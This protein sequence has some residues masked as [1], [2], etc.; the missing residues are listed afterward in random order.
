MGTFRR[1]CGVLLALSMVV[2]GSTIARAQT[3]PAAAPLQAPELT[4]AQV[5]AAINR[6]LDFLIKDIDKK[7][8]PVKRAADVDRGRPDLL[9]GSPGEFMLE[10]YALLYAGQELRDP[11]LAFRDQRVQLIKD[12]VTRLESSKLQN[13]ETYTTALQSL[14]LSQMPRV[15][16]VTNAVNRVTK[17]LVGGTTSTGGYEYKL[18]DQNWIADGSNS[19]YGLLGVW[20]A[21][22]WG[23][24]VPYN[25]WKF[26]DEY[27]R[28]VQSN[29]GGW[30]YGQRPPE[31]ARTGT[32]TASMTA[33]GL[34]SL[35]VCGEFLDRTPHLDM[36]SDAVIDKGMAAFVDMFD[37]K[38]ND[39]YYLYGVE[40]VGLASGLKFIGNTNWYRVI[41]ANLVKTQ[42]A[43]GSFEGEFLGANAV[44]GTCYALLFLVRGRAPIVMNKLQYDGDW[45][46][47]PRDSANVHAYLT[48][49]FER[50]LNWQVVPVGVP[51]EEWLDAP[52]LYIAGSK[53]PNFS[54]E[55]VEKLKAFVA[56]GGIIFSVAEGGGQ[57]AGKA[58]S[59]AVAGYAA[60]IL[61]HT[62]PADADGAPA[63]A[64]R[65]LPKD[66]PLFSVIGRPD[67]LPRLMGIS[68]GV[69]ELW[70][71]S[72][73]DYGAIWQSRDE[74]DKNTW[75]LPARIFM[76][77]AS[78]NGLHSKLQ[79]LVAANDH[80]SAASMN[81]ARLE[82]AGNWDPEPGAWPRLAK[83]LSADAHT[84]LAIDTV[85]PEQLDSLA[86]KPALAHLAGVGNLQLTAEQGRALQS[87]VTGG[88]TL[89]VEAMAGD[90]AFATS[91][92][93]MLAGLFPDA[94]LKAVPDD[95]LLYTGAFS[96]DAAHITEVEY[97][98]NWILS[99]GAQSKPRLQYM[100][101]EG[102]V[103]VLFSEEDIT[104]GLLGL[105]TWGVDGYVPDSAVA[106]ARNIVL[107]A[108]INQKK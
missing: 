83:L 73:T 105:N 31:A 2:V 40:R 78:K 97:R 38:S 19:Q 106:L 29:N 87:Y 1:A 12:V 27:W 23:A 56:Q 46:A 10:S 85:K 103:G 101:V 7:L 51:V 99:H 58:F 82:F 88:G 52:V 95:Y 90:K 15:P 43:D 86:A 22:D 68:N 92:K 4:D 33:A 71:H 3:R 53:D 42:R 16:E 77:I 70:I 39:L 98:K 17:R 28:R 24:T 13:Y 45:D 80:P 74:S 75:E 104:H 18:A 102:R 6:G 57:G 5:M 32:S 91:A 44:H 8:E 81:M 62:G 11:R 14:A 79:S 65:E 100:T 54:D 55:Q 21:A 84:S 64:W 61:P 25:Y 107:F 26:T 9:G 72:D 60:R 59:A 34:A 69:R 50:R 63:A 49:I 37:A 30:S 47:R 41:A 48:R 36:R 89:F 35:M 20:A 76:Y 93:E 94:S 108:G 67:P 96:P 66:H